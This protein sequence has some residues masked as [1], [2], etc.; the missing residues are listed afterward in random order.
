M[1][2]WNR[3]LV[4]DA[5]KASPDLNYYRDLFLL[6]PFLGFSISAISNIV[7]PRSAA[8]RI[9]GLKLAVCA[10]VALLLAKEKRI[11][12][13]AA[14]AYVALKMA[15]GIIFIHTWQILAWLLVSGGILLSALRLGV[16]ENWKPSYVW[17]KK[18]RVLDVA[19]V[20]LGLGVMMAIGSWMKP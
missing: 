5:F 9:F 7:M 8:Y 13:I 2:N 18:L 15:F 6:W 20:M 11:P 17:P 19:V 16:L 10:V 1:P 3:I 4:G 14:S 12:F